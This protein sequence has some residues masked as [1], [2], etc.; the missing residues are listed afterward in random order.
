MHIDQEMLHHHYH[1][2][3]HHHHP[4]SVIITIIKHTIDLW[5]T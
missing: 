5:A 1:Q 3:H 2:Y 4:I